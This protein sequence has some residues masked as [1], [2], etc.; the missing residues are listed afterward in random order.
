MVAAGEAPFVEPPVSLVI[1][2]DGPGADGVLQLLKRARSIRGAVRSLQLD[3]ALHE[4]VIVELEVAPNLLTGP[5][6]TEPLRHTGSMHPG[7]GLLPTAQG[8]SGSHESGMSVRTSHPATVRRLS[9][10]A[11]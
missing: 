6:I 1:V 11:P 5:M 10:V 2:V 8:A 4:P 9:F 7:E 3:M